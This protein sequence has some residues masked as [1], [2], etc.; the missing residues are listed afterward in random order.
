VS[1]TT[2][3]NHPATSAVGKSATATISRSGGVGDDPTKTIYPKINVAYYD[4]TTKHNVPQAIWD[5]LNDQGPVYNSATG[6]TTNAR[7]SDPWF[8]ATGLPISEAYWAHVKVAGQ[9]QD[10]LIQAFERRV[11]TYIPNGVPGFKV[12]MGNIGQHYYDWRYKGA[13][14]PA[15]LPPSNQPTAVITP[16]PTPNTQHPTPAPGADC[17]GIPPAQNMRVVPSNCGPAGTTFGFIGSGFQPGE[18]VSAYITFPDQAV[19]GPPDCA[20]PTPFKADDNGTLSIG[21]TVRSGAPL[22]V[23]ATT[24]EGLTTHN[25]AIGYFKVIGNSPPPPGT[26][27]PGASSCNDVPPSQNVSI[28]PSNCAS[29]GTSFSFT[30]RGFQ[31]NEDVTVY[32][33]FPDQSVCGPPDCAPAAPFKA[34]GNGSLRVGLGTRPNSPLG[35]WAITMEGLSAHSKAIGYFKLTPP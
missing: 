20:P 5:F 15:N 35:I 24:M 25:K 8:Y 27:N 30:G 18:D 13:G 28:A 2:V 7:L 33:T 19:C 22:G 11:V 6:K 31:P 23:W 9:M 10:V 32:I 1:N 26:P 16:S 14:R 17:S 12:Q 29:A 3:G 21:L 34:D 4:A